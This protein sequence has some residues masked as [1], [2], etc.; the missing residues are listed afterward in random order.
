MRSIIPCLL[1]LTACDSGSDTSTTA[2][3]LSSDT[4]VPLVGGYFDGG[5]VS[6]IHTEVS[7]QE[8]ADLLTM[9]MGPD[10]I[11]VPALAEAPASMLSSLYVFTNGTTGMGPFGFQPDIFDSVPG[12]DG[13]QPLR[14]IMLV[15]WTT[16]D[17]T[18]LTSMADL[19]AA[20]S[21]G[22]VT[23]TDSGIVV[24]APVLRWPGGER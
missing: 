1:L 17:T 10:V 8:V 7:D 24:N 18:E 16:S 13:Y 11:V 3:A 6:F 12:E 20:V 2:A 19:D 23:V 15:E 21:A 14:Q 4:Y 5:E 22:T 9:M